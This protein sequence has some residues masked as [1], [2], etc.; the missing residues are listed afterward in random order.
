M[1]KL[2]MAEIKRD[3]ITCLEKKIIESNKITV[4]M[5]NQTV[6]FFRTTTELREHA[7]NCMNETNNIKRLKC[8]QTVRNNIKIFI[9][10]K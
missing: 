7:D 10:P 3:S 9:G 1:V 6:Q 4:L 2:A 5:R 8:I